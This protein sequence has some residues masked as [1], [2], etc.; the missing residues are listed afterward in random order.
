MLCVIGLPMF[1]I[2]Y[3]ALGTAC[4]FHPFPEMVS[5][6]QSIIGIEAREQILKSA[7]RLPDRVYA[8]VGGGSNAMGAF[9]PF[10]KED[11]VRLI[12]VEAGGKGVNDQMLMQL[13]LLLE[14][15]VCCMVIEHI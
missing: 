12:G 15:S 9:Y 14:V 11:D 6:F 13:R 10:I 5:W 4:G 7:G 8:C 2:H 1:K 3:Y